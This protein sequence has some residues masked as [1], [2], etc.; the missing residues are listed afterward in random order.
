MKSTLTHQNIIDILKQLRVCYSLISTDWADLEANLID[1]MKKCAITELDVEPVREI[2]NELE[3]KYGLEEWKDK[4]ERVY[5]SLFVLVLSKRRSDLL[6]KSVKEFLKEFPDYAKCDDSELNLLLKFRNMMKCGII[7]Y[8]AKSNKGKLMDIAGRLSGKLFTLGGGSTIEAKRREAIYEQ[9]GGVTKKKLTVPRKR[10][11]KEEDS[12]LNSTGA[13]RVKRARMVPPRVIRIKEDSAVIDELQDPDLLLLD[14]LP[15]DS[16]TPP[17]SESWCSICP[18]KPTGTSDPPT[19]PDFPRTRT[20][21]FSGDDSDYSGDGEWGISF[22]MRRSGC[23][24]VSTGQHSAETNTTTR[25]NL[26]RPD[27]PDPLLIQRSITI[28][29]SKPLFSDDVFNY[30]EPFFPC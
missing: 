11:V 29:F 10:K 6:L 14:P 24:H 30:L 5:R 19:P 26:P 12:S 21:S 23:S 16:L 1:V 25:S 28:D 18:F 3:K 7:L 4:I 2:I 9:L 13:K 22:C 15:A 17:L 27:A 8:N 20:N